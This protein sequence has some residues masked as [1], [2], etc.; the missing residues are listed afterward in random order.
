MN[1]IE[2]LAEYLGIKPYKPFFYWMV[3]RYTC[4]LDG[5][6]YRTWKDNRFGDLAHDM[7]CDTSFPR[8]SY[9]TDEILTHLKWKRACQEA[10]DTAKQALKLYRAYVRIN[11]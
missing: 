3:I 8:Q 9:D 1:D 6:G 10:I 2:Q 4:G 5:D 7:W 11:E